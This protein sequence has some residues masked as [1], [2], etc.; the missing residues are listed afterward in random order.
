M[1]ELTNGY[2]ELGVGGIIAL[3]I[4][5]EVLG[6]LRNREKTKV[7]NDNCNFKEK[8]E[9][10]E[11]NMENKCIERREVCAKSLNQSF[12]LLAT[13]VEGKFSEIKSSIDIIG[14]T[15]KQQKEKLDKG[16]DTFNE[17]CIEIQQLK[18]FVMNNNNPN[19]Y[20]RRKE[21]KLKGKGRCR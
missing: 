18:D 15:Q 3:M 16:D 7:I 21:D 4:I 6:F 12:E 8:I 2:L 19:Y 13:K 5:K 14:S 17:L 11:N 10:V 1:T 9:I 20:N